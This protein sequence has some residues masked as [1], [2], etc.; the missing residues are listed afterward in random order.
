[1]FRSEIARRA[2]RY[3]E[4]A[5]HIMNVLP[6]AVRTP[7]GEEVVRLVF[8]AFGDNARSSA[9]LSSLRN[10]YDKLDAQT[11]E[12]WPMTVLALEWFA[13]LGSMDDAHAVARRMVTRLERTGRLATLNLPP[14]WLPELAAFR[15]DPRFHELAKALGFV[16][17]WKATRPPDGYVL[18]ADR[19]VERSGA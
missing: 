9:A 15:R 16:E 14:L 8:G 3:A 11:A 2:G 13:L 6:A 17:Y 12:G 4:A 10:L 18:Q 1:I 7:D 5:E 19:L